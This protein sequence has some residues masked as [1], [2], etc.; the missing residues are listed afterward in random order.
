MSIIVT[1]LTILFVLLLIKMIFY[2]DLFVYDTINE[3]ETTTTTVTTTTTE[4]VIDRDGM[5][6]LIRAYDATVRSFFVIDPADGDVVFLQPEDDIYEDG[7][8]KWYKLV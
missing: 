1:I 3:V 2:P 5:P 7:A 4:T 8:G 6:P